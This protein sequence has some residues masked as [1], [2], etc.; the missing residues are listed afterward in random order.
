MTAIY[1]AI[2]QEQII[3]TLHTYGAVVEHGGFEYNGSIPAMEGVVD[4]IKNAFT[5][6]WE[7]IPFGKQL[8]AF[9]ETLHKLEK[10]NV[11][12][13]KVNFY[14]IENFPVLVIE[15]YIPGKNYT[16]FGTLLYNQ[17]TNLITTSQDALGEF[18]TYV[19]L[20]SNNQ[21]KRNEFPRDV[22]ILVKDVTK[23]TQDNIKQL[24]EY[25]DKAKTNDVVTV[26][27]VFK[28]VD[29]IFKSKDIAL[30][31]SKYADTKVLRGLMDQAQ[32]VSVLI[33]ALIENIKASKIS[34]SKEN[35]NMLI[36]ASDA[37][38]KLLEQLATDYYFSTFYAESMLELMNRL[39]KYKG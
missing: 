24:S 9:Q 7:Y 13:I 25:I 36:S 17:T 3:K 39:K 23:V 34:L 28:N 1:T 10:I 31:M 6:L 33:D 32:T 21:D 15:G 16:E 12:K 8:D 19:G 20:L 2:E 22:K 11:R 26:S 4:V 29:D 35:Y 30:S 37:M 18:N 38:A 5:K 14:V 27:M